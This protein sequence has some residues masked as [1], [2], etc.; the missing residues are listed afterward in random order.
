MNLNFLS[1]PLSLSI[2]NTVL[3]WSCYRPNLNG[4]ISW[5][6]QFSRRIQICAE[7]NLH[8]ATHPTFLLYS[9]QMHDFDF[10]SPLYLL[11][12]WCFSKNFSWWFSTTAWLLWKIEACS[13]LCRCQ[14]KSF[15]IW[16]PPL[17]TSF[18]IEMS[19]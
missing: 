19:L 12:I 9:Y 15:E 8:F 5:K 14:N 11:V 1:H 2:M 16:Q 3:S 6:Y 18:P 17:I 10:W 4:C 7:R 13:S